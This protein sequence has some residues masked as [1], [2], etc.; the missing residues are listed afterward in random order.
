ML[1][2]QCQTYP[3]QSVAFAADGRTLTTADRCS[4]R[5][6]DLGGGKPRRGV[7]GKLFGKRSHSGQ[8]GFVPRGRRGCDNRPALLAGAVARGY[9]GIKSCGIA[10]D[11]DRRRGRERPRA[12]GVQR[13]V[14]RHADLGVSLRLIP[15]ARARRPRPLGAPSHATRSGSVRRRPH[16]RPHPP[17]LARSRRARVQPRTPRCRSPIPPPPCRPRLPPSTS[18]P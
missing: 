3:V 4:V 2:L 7:R 12:H 10:A 14:R 17:A 16:A 18:M 9:I 6:W 11:G 5:V 13:H 8:R 15:R 1:R